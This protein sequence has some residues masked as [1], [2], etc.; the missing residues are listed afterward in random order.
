VSALAAGLLAAGVA[1]AAVFLASCAPAKRDAEVA[2][3]DVDDARPV[4]GFYAELA[5]FGRWLEDPVQGWV[6]TPYDM[7]PLWRPYT[8]GQWVWSNEGW[9]WISDQPWGWATEHHGRWR[10]DDDYGW[11]W[12]PGTEWAPAWVTWRAGEDWVGWAPVPP[13]TVGSDRTTER[14]PVDDAWTFVPR[15]RVLDERPRRHAASIVR[16][17][18]L[19]EE[20][21]PLERSGGDGAGI[22]DSGP[23]PARMAW[24][25][26]PRRVVE[27]AEPVPA[28]RASDT[29]VVT[30]YRPRITGDP[31]RDG[32]P[33]EVRARP[34]DGP[35]GRGRRALEVEEERLDRAIAGVRTR[36]R[37]FHAREKLDQTEDEALLHERQAVERKRLDALERRLR[38]II[39]TRMEQGL[40]P[41][42]HPG[43]LDEGENARERAR[44]RGG[45]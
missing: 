14:T 39:E 35:A 3:P 26:T 5:P 24:S 45:D 19:I 2:L 1:V 7:D 20:T 25:V 31:R 10:P 17:R 44:R 29:S 23:D 28:S 16:N 37:D 30:V 6:W 11:V 34:D 33:P 32:P 9:I 18:T 36:L 40:V 38:R 12:V 21:R 41:P 27:A 42:L 8:V 43:Q 15:D 4:S 13:D 22:V